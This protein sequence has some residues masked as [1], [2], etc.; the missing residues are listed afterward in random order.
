MT[1]I[2]DISA[3]LTVLETVIKQLITHMAVRDDN[4]PGWVRTRRTLAISALEGTLDGATD[5]LHDAV[6]DFFAQA[7]TVAQ[8]YAYSAKQGTVRPFM[9]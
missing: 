3:R 8:Q 7:E 5:L 4:P 9:R 2:D 1:E 6:T